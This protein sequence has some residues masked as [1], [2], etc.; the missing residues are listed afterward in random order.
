MFKAEAEGGQAI[1][2]GSGSLVHQT[3]QSLGPGGRKLK[4]VDSGADNLFGDDDENDGG[5]AKRRAKEYG[6]E[7]DMDEVVYE[8]DFADDEEKMEVEDSND[9][10]AKELEVLILVPSLCDAN[11]VHI[12]NG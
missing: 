7:G 2:G 11:S 8:E 5:A 1:V 6:G 10:E 12:R 3:Q 4:T 9:Q